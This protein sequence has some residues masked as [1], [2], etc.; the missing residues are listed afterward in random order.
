[1][2]QHHVRQFREERSTHRRCVILE[3]GAGIVSRR[4]TRVACPAASN[5]G[6]SGSATADLS[7]APGTMTNVDTAPSRTR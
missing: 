5:Q 7:Y 4:S 2:D 3:R 1:M 6:T